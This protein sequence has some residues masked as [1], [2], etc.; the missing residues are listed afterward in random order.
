MGGQGLQGCKSSVSTAVTR[1]QHVPMGRG[2]CS[3]SGGWVPTSPPPLSVLLML[4]H[5]ER[6]MWGGGRMEGDVGRRKGMKGRMAQPRGS[7]NRGARPGGQERV[8]A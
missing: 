8:F 4:C 3:N 2:E 1:F 5:P 6:R 7:G